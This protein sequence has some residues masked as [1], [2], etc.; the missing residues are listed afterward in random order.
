MAKPKQERR[1][2]VG[3][4]KLR[5][6]QLVVLRKGAQEISDDK[7]GLKFIDAEEHF[8]Y[9]IPVRKEQMEMRPLDIVRQYEEEQ[10]VD[11][12]TRVADRPDDIRCFI[13]TKI[14]R[15]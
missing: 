13:A 14:T 11:P 12:A 1:R 4:R 3:T 5:R 7:T 15:T 8:V 10:G 9:L 6:P 2:K